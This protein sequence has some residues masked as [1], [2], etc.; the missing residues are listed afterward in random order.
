M[1]PT[2]DKFQISEFA[3]PDI[4]HAPVYS[5]VWNGKCSQEETVRQ[6]EEM[7]RLGIKAFYIIPE[8]KTFR[9]TTMP[10][11]LEPDY[12][13]PPYFAQYQF[14]METARQMGMQ[15]WIYDEGG[16]PSGGACGKVLLDHPEFARRSL[17]CK[18]VAVKKGT[19]YEKSSEDVIAAF[20]PDGALLPE[21]TV[22]PEDRVVEE[23]IS[24]RDF[25][26][27]PGIPDYPDIL[28][29]E[30]TKEF[31]RITHEAY[32]PYLEPFFGKHMTAVFTDEPKAPTDVPFHPSMVGLYEQI[33]GESVLPALPV[34]AGRAEPDGETAKHLRQWYNL[35]SKLFC[36]NFLLPCK[37]WAN[38]NGMLFTGHMDKDDEPTGCMSGCNYHLM[39]ALR[40]LDIP[41]I[42]V[43]WRQIHPGEKQKISEMCQTS[44]NGFFPRY[45]SS[46]AAQN[47]T[48]YA[49]TESFGVY[50]SGLTYDEMR[51]T[52][53][54]QAIRGINIFNIM[55]LSYTRKGHMMTGEL[56]VF[57]EKQ[58]CHRDL[59]TFNAYME[60]LSYTTSLGQR[61]YD[62]ALFYPVQDFWGRVRSQ[63]MA[64]R[65]DR[66][67]WALENRHVDFDIVDED[68]LLSATG[69]EEG[70]ICHGKAKYRQILIPEGAYLSPEAEAVLAR[71]R[72]G[73]GKI[74]TTAEEVRVESPV[75]GEA[76]ML[77]VMRR[78]L[79]GGEL[80]C[81]YNEY[82]HE[83]QFCVR[84]PA[85]RN[86]LINITE[87]KTEPLL[88]QGDTVR[89]DL[90]SGEACAIYTTQEILATELPFSPECSID[91]AHF[92]FSRTE[93]FVLG[94]MTPQLHEICE[95]AVPIA[96]GDWSEVTGRDFSGSGKYTTSFA[97]P[98]ERLRDRAVLELGDV[99]YSCECVLNGVCLGVKVMHPYRFSVPE[100]LLR[101]QNTL[102]IRVSNTAANQHA[103]TKTFDKWK[104]WQISV[105]YPI[106]QRFHPD[107]LDSGLYGPVRLVFAK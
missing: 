95:R 63:E 51:Y 49:M 92:A 98:A 35:C 83:E 46:A 37:Q 101:E 44:V 11:E 68:I 12:L 26:A 80:L 89:L 103:Y 79:T 41:G 106:Q 43:I 14:A 48:D 93:S 67:G 8:P 91:L 96:L 105:Y 60:R 62:T 70:V 28:L 64:D 71:F 50:G 82:D 97:L 85:G 90:A 24:E 53:G 3:Q 5:W 2:S 7:Q 17:A 88:P 32:K 86:Y 76:P 77:R 59:A 15:C 102:E 16:W 81:L 100:G 25:F 39:R 29:G 33:Y 42:D 99:R 107:S 9:P 72:S 19:A 58:A 4:R 66:E 75:V 55:L 21:G 94:D 56:P 104:P 1:Y 65:F 10:T 47:G 18:E 13:T 38:E 36:E 20:G 74:C 45:A 40:C 57:S 34:L 61:V 31:L 52:L 23:Y 87:G 6:L 84:V 22:L 73:G 78:K 54:Y 30:A 27:T 69:A